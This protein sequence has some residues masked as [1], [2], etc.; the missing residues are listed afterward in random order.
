MSEVHE[1]G[2]VCGAIRYR[3]MGEPLRAYVCHCTFCQRFTGSAFGVL[4]WFKKE[5]VEVVGDGIVTYD[6]TVDETDRWFRLH[7]CGRCATTFM[8]T[9]QRQP[10]ICYI[11]VGT[12]D[13]PNWV[14][15]TRQL[16]TRS[17]Q[18]WVTMPDHWNVTRKA[19]S[20]GHQ[21]PDIDSYY[22]DA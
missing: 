15:L 21:S 16:W 4:T 18:H 10:N 13:D 22:T 6:H 12:Y 20:T 19:L 3:V 11:F 7:S 8:G 1:G 14:Q 17:A 9:T 2:C 5:N